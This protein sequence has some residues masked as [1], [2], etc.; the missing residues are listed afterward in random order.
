MLVVIE[1]QIPVGIPVVV[2]VVS[3]RINLYE[4]NTSLDQSTSHQALSTEVLGLV[5]IDSVEGFC[6][7]IFGI[8]IDRFGS[9]ALHLVGQFVTGDACGKIG[10]SDPCRGMG[11]VFATQVIEHGSLDPTSQELWRFK[12]ENRWPLRTENG[13]LVLGGHVAAR[14]VLCS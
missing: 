2:V 14:P 10:V 13:A 6:L 12:V 8:D 1:L 11:F 5:S 4:A 3:A 7:L 9:R